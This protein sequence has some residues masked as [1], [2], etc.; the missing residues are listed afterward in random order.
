MNPDLE[1]PQHLEL[2]QQ[3]FGELPHQPQL[4]ASYLGRLFRAYE[5]LPPAPVG[6]VDLVK[7]ETDACIAAHEDNVTI[8]TPVLVS[9]TVSEPTDQDESQPPYISKMPVSSP[10]DEIPD[11]LFD[12]LVALDYQDIAKSKT[13]FSMKRLFGRAKEALTNKFEKKN[14]LRGKLGYVALSA[15]ALVP[16]AAVVKTVNA[17]STQLPAPQEVVTNMPLQPNLGGTV[18]VVVGSTETI[19]YSQNQLDKLGS[20]L[21]APRSAKV[22]TGE[23]ATQ[24]MFAALDQMV[25]TQQENGFSNDQMRA[26]LD[27]A[28]AEISN[29]QAS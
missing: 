3:A 28:A 23:A 29:Q 20:I 12:E 15:L 21:T 13:S 14:R 9:E 7:I 5:P 8:D 6:V 18:H 22:A 17:Q 24:E 27:L 10:E 2:P 16:T 26:V 11:A 25:R 1:V 4:R 19:G